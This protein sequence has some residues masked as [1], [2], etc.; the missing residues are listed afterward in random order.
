MAATTPQIFIP[1]AQYV[2]TLIPDGLV[3]LPDIS[4]FDDIWMEP[5]NIQTDPSLSVATA[6][7]FDTSLT[8]GIPGVDAVKLVLAPDGNA[9]SFMLQ[10]TTDPEPTVSLVDVPIALR[11]SDDVLKPVK[12]VPGQNGQPDTW[13]VDT[14]V[15]HVDV[16]LAKVTLSIDVDGN[17]AVQTDLSIDLPPAMIG[18]S[19]VVV[20]AEDI[21]IYLDANNPPPGK[22]AGWRGVHIGSAAVHLPGG[23]SGTIGT[24]AATDCYIGNGG[25]SGH[26][27]DTWS[28]ALGATIFGM[29]CS[30][31]SAEVT[32]VQNSLTAAAVKGSLTLPFFDE[33]AGVEIGFAINGAFS[34]KLSDSSGLLTLTKA[35]VLEVKVDSLGFDVADGLYTVHVSGELTPLLGGLDW[36]GFE[37]KDLSIDSQGN[38]R[39]EGGWIDLP[40][41]YAL[42][43]HG[44][45]VTV[46]KLG[47]GKTDDGGK[48]IGFSGGLQLVDGLSAGAS[49]DG[50][51]VTWY[52]D[53]RAAKIT[54][55]GVGVELEIPNVL[56]FKGAVSYKEPSPGVHRFDGAI[57]LDLLALDLEID[58]QLVIGS[59]PDYTFLA[60][61]LDCELPA[62]I[63]L[64]ATGLGLYGMAGLFALNMGPN[65][66][67]DQPWYEIGSTSDWFHSPQVGVTDLATK[68]TNVDGGLAVGAGVTIGTE[69][70]NGYTFSAKMLL[71]LSFPGPVILLQG[72]ANVLKERAALSDDPLFRALVVLDANAGSF[73]VGLDVHYEN[74]DA[75]QLIDIHGG[76]ELFFSTADPGGWHLYLGEKDPREKRIRAEIFQLFEAD[77]Y[78]MLDARQLATGAWIGYDKSWNFGPLSVTVEAWI[79]GNVVLSWK[80]TQLHGD[81]WLH[82]KAALKAFGI[83]LGLTVDAKVAADVF[84]PFDVKAEFSVSVDLPWPL[85]DV[86][87][88]ITIEFGPRPTPPPIPLPLKEIAV[89]HFKVT[90]SWPLPRTSSPALLA[91]NYDA[92]GFLSPYPPIAS[93]AT[94]AAAAAP[95]G[96]EPVVPLDARPHITF[97]RAVHDR[98]RVG[99]NAQPVN[100]ACE[101]IGDPSKNQGPTEVRYSLVEIDLHSWDGSSWRLVARAAADANPA[102]IS[103][104]YGSWAPMPAM[105]DGGGANPA[106]VK[107][108]LWSKTPFDYTSHTGSSWDEWFTARY[109]EY[110][111]VPAPPTREYCLYFDD[112]PIG[113]VLSSPVVSDRSGVRMSWQNGV[114]KPI[115]AVAPAVDG[116]THRL[117][118]SPPQTRTTSY[119]P[120]PVTVAIT[121][122]A[123]AS[124]V[125]V[126]MAP[127]VIGRQ[128]L[129]DSTAQAIGL[130]AAGNTYGPFTAQGGRIV[131][132]GDAMTSVAVTGDPGL[133]VISVCC[134][135]AATAADRTE[136]EA[137][138]RH[139]QDEL[140]CWSQTGDVLEPNTRYRLTVVTAVETADEN[141]APDPQISEVA[142][143]RTQGPPGLAALSTP[144][145]ADTASF[146]SGLSDLVPYVGQTVPATVPAVGQP[147]AL[148]KPVYRGYDVGVQFNEDYVDLMY[149]AAGRDL[150]LYLFDRNNR[151]VRDARGA[152]IVLANRWG[153]ADH[154]TLTASEQQWIAVVNSSRCSQMD[155]AGIP[156]DVNL[157]ALGQVLD[158]DTVY[159]ARLIPLLLHETF[160]ELAAG[161]AASGP[162]GTLGRWTVHDQPNTTG[163]P[164]SWSVQQSG[165]PATSS[166]RQTSGIQGGSGASDDPVSP[167]ALLLCADDPSEPS[168]DQAGNWTDYRLT[169]IMRGADG[170]AI[171]AVF[172]YQ[173]DDTYYR[174]SMDRQLGYRRLVRVV[175]GTTT[176]LAEDDTVYSADDDYQITI[177]AVGPA[178][179]VYQDGD[180]VFAVSD[181]AIDHGRVGLYCWAE[182]GAQ[183][184]DV[185]VDDFRRAAATPYRFSF[186]TSDYVD[187]VHHLHS[188]Q[189]ETW[190]Q[191]VT[192]DVA[193]LLSAAVAPPTAPTAPGDAETRAYE[194]LA[195]AVLGQGARANP[196]Q[197]QVTRIEKD[198]A[199]LA[200][201]VQ[202]PEPIDFTRS[203]VA[204]EHADVSGPAPSTPGTAKL[205]DAEF[206]STPNAESV[207]VLL[208][209]SMDISRH[210][211][212]RRV[213][214]DPLDQPAGDPT[215]LYDDFRG[216][217]AG[218]LLTETFGPNALDHYTIIDRGGNDG[219]SHW[220]TSGGKLYQNSMIWGIG[221]TAADR[222]GSVAVTGLPDWSDVRLAAT[223]MSSQPYGI[224]LVFRHTDADNHYRFS[225]DNWGGRRQ[226]VRTAGGIATLLGDEPFQFVVS[227]SYRVEI[228]AIGNRFIVFVDGELVFD[229]TDDGPKAGRVG[230]YSWCNAGAVFDS[231]TVDAIGADP[232]VWSPPFADMAEVHVVD[233]A[234][235]TGGPSQWSVAD[236]AL[237]QTSAIT[238]V[239]ATA[240]QP[241][242]YAVG[243]PVC[244]DAVVAVRLRT[245]A[246]GALGLMFRYIDDDNYYRVVLDVAG[247]AIRL[248]KRVAGAS[249]ELWSSNQSLSINTDYQ[250]TVTTVGAHLRGVLNGAALFAVTDGD[251][252]AGQTAL[253]CRAD[254]GASFSDVLVLDADQRIGGWTTH[255]AATASGPSVWSLADGQ[256]RQRA[257][258]GDPTMPDAPG[259]MATAGTADWTDYRL[260]ATLHSDSD[261]GIGVVVRYSSDQDYYR[262][263]MNSA[264][265]DRRLLKVSGGVVS[266][267]WSD[268]VPYPVGQDLPVVIDA[269]GPRLVGYLDGVRLF[270][271]ADD[272]NPAGGVGLYAWRNPSASFSSVLVSQPP[273]DAY[274][275]FADAFGTGAMTGFRV[276][277]EGTAL[278]PSQ[279]SVTDG[280][281][282]QASGIYEP[283][284]DRD[285]LSKRGT[286]A[287]AGDP[288]WTDVVLDVTLRSLD[289][290][291]LG[292]VVRHGDR[293]NY[294]RFSIDS[295]RKCRRLVKS[296]G[297]AFTALWQ[298]S[299]SYTVGQSYRITIAV[300]GDELRGYVDGVLAFAVVDGDLPAG[301]VGLYTWNEAGARF[302]RVRVYPGSRARRGWLLDDG[303]SLASTDGWAFVDDG[304]SGGPS[305]WSVDPAV[306][307]RQTS[308]ITSPDREGTHAYA[309]D[310]SWTDYRLSVRLAGGATGGAGVLARYVDVDNY[311]RFSQDH[312]AGERRLERRLAGAT[313]ILWQD[314][315]SFAVGRE[316]VVT[317]D[318]VGDHVTGYVDGVAVFAVTDGALPAGAVGLCSW[319]DP[320]A[321]FRE[322]R[323][324]AM[325]WIEH[326]T[327][328]E[329]S[330]Q[331]AGARFAICSGNAADPPTPQDNV[332]YRFA[333]QLDDPAAV[334][335]G[336]D[337][338][339]LRLV[340]PHG[341]VLHGREFLAP[342][343]YSAMP[344][345]VLRRED[346]TGLAIVPAAVG[347]ALTPGQHRIRLAYARDNRA[348][349]PTSPVLTENGSAAPEVAQLDVPW[350]AHSG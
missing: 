267:L 197:V 42:D 347:E 283:P 149:R 66:A 322:V 200:L 224:G 65:K 143:F 6:L 221:S 326:F 198:G 256:L 21:G 343:A 254:P 183:F 35:G 71:V 51:R 105:P 342:T 232:V 298:D 11:F 201:L 207:T 27:S 219:P 111:C 244:R 58:G 247:G 176:V 174:F 175:A 70:D 184:A 67:P 33:P 300:V 228:T 79:D 166:V 133:C 203:T 266:T 123:P 55:A 28:P 68:W 323:V 189:D 274:A 91:P 60:I 258:I 99:V 307:L 215:L 45:T 299:I 103:K 76:C 301:Q 141:I 162:S 122:P 81:L 49:V 150:G 344:V 293:D 24:L 295:Q 238:V 158:A 44:F 292:V 108:W 85:P 98:A 164:S 186:T 106:Q 165:S 212:E 104:L 163:G 50:L 316:Y 137:M 127:R 59:T 187:V 13:V 170:G 144:V 117:C 185:R 83:G 337:G 153:H 178:L 305:A 279:W 31:V 63:P 339:N 331:P 329:E 284:I 239:D 4:A 346:G 348:V 260:A 319:D 330:P 211:I 281:S 88:D 309:G 333:A 101:R 145:N 311:Y 107:L 192:T 262:F 264:G 3:E 289:G 229:I 251:L 290:S 287:L 130:D 161:A 93:L 139:L 102:G 172:R 210:R 191:T 233:P 253:Y 173:D 147:P 47:F 52:D 112:V 15:D 190:T 128:V 17:I 171:G 151:P 16:T 57:S 325:D 96:N 110:P 286:T 318:C 193:D 226:L 22:P 265:R 39:I 118:L 315:T 160:D 345:R 273:L 249:T 268:S 121:P 235:A 257:A 328:A 335:F 62:G 214:P 177:E 40:A 114:A 241:G 80:P 142:Y 245:S 237:R 48:W 208:R 227:Q 148:P 220:F 20:E 206:G 74:D 56:R 138:T 73:L 230:C 125:V 53:G 64:W 269:V 255:D 306:G 223:L 332:Q 195:D 234:G 308:A 95:P 46:T 18:D 272:A 285:T 92:G 242:A 199:A 30:L 82:G 152:L 314:T 25:F 75:G 94:A 280:E 41:Q 313:T 136:Q 261:Q 90:T 7:L 159:E 8:V 77:A 168:A 182:T 26:V 270:D 14:T 278:G 154:V 43:F 240:W 312:T 259:T 54:L 9:T 97:G 327:F 297:G 34:V 304:T 276:D 181:A 341:T 146:D 222:L 246:A 213:A 169:L 350:D 248:T 89:E 338:V 109:P 134:T 294:Y 132:T 216:P 167:G 37:L 263:A 86:G 179:A 252:A 194:G 113:T 291:C 19:G 310:P 87:A 225:M 84:D 296:V 336:A 303:F 324:A 288:T 209:D 218:R 275:V 204:V 334:H 124:E 205:I 340:D 231:L 277:D 78:F 321:V 29:K 217:A 119:K 129:D 61:Y 100:P 10:L 302:S 282:Q 236:G 156:R 135:C 38:V 317:V 23:L 1:V 250:L 320:A 140:A 196:P 5:L 32:F 115:T 36:P 180:P 69:A 12:K 155:T 126:T 72:A 2:Q 188:Y 120:P 349:A 131:I 116:H 271:V 202:S 243:G 157:S